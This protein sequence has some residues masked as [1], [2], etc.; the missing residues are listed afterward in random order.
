M[1]GRP[2]VNGLIYYVAAAV[3][4]AGL[5]AQIP[6]LL[7]YRRD[8]LKWTFCVVIFLSGLC[9]LLGAPPTV[10]LV[11]GV[12]GVPNMAAPLTYGAVTAFSAASLILIV[13]W[14]GADL[15]TAR[16]WLVSYAAVILAQSILFG[17][18]DTPVERREDFDTYYA[19]TPFIREMIVLYL[20]AHV[21]AALTTT[22]LCW[23]WTRQV[24]RWTR[25][26]MT[27]LV[28]GW[29]FTSAYSIVKFVSL[30]AHWLGRD[31][32]SLSTRVAPLIALGACLTS[33][34][35]ILPVIGPR[36]DSGLT[37][38]RLRRLFRLLGTPPKPSSSGTPLSWKALG[39]I[40]LRLTTRETA[41][42]DGLRRLANLFD[43]QVG[44]R[45]H[46]EALETGSSPAAAEAIA[47][48]AMIAV[49]A[50]T[51]VHSPARASGTI[52][53]TV[54]DIDLVVPV[55]GYIPRSSAESLSVVTG[56]PSLLSLARAMR[57]PIVDAAVQ[58]RRSRVGQP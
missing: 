37:Y 47:M 43:D 31:W 39:D 30:T 24:K 54:G 5:A 17:L 58:S 34:G 35:Y 16:A 28:T 33:A 25:A 1:N 27:L 3:L 15:R 42:R 11:N 19:S 41:I 9:F 40:S 46:R 56:Q 45:A 4:W 51:E 23:R 14:R 29:L 49:A 10:A 50:L 52:A 21:V 53:I 57:T 2:E 13:Q 36:I 7:R 12:T 48:A 26:S 20:A 55:S 8:P 32:D 38:I 6:D 22:V 18:G 44:Q